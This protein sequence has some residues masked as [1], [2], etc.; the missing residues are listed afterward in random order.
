[1]VTS[2]TRL[3]LTS[4]IILC[5]FTVRAADITQS[6]SKNDMESKNEETK[7]IE[8]LNFF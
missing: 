1:M 2:F 7:G 4:I 6:S 8:N 5:V 3:N